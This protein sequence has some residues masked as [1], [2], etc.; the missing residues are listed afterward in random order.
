MNAAN[1]CQLYCQP[2]GF[3]GVE[4]CAGRA[5]AYPIARRVKCLDLLD[6]MDIRRLPHITEKDIA[7][8]NYYR[9]A[10]TMI[11]AAD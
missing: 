5:A 11:E 8:L 9:D 1:L 2:F 6:N 7:S 10:L 4:V 3:A